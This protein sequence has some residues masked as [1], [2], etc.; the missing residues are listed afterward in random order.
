MGEIISALADLAEGPAVG[1]LM[2]WV[3]ISDTSQAATG[4][5][6]KNA[7]RYGVGAQVNAQT[8]T[9]YTYLTTDFRKLVTHTNAAAIAGTLPQAGAT[10]PAGWYMLVQNRGAGALTITPTTSTVDDAATLVLNQNEGAIVVSDGT[11]YFTFRGKTAIGAGGS[12]PADATYIVQTA[13][14]SLSA[15][16]AL[17][18]LAT[19]LL[20]S[21]TTTGVVSIATAGDIS[22][23]L[24][25][26]DAVGS[27]AYAITL[28]PAIAAYA[29]GM[30]ITFKAGT[31]NTGGATL[32]VNGLAAKAIV[33]SA[34][35]L[36]TALADNDIRAGQI[37]VVQYSSA[38]DNFQMQ[39]MLGNTAAAGSTNPTSTVIPY[40]S[41]GSFADSPLARTDAN[42]I[43]H[44]NGTS[45]TSVRYNLYGVKNGSDFE[46]FSWYYD[47]VNSKYV[48]SVNK[49]GTG[50][51]RNI[52]LEFDGTAFWR[53]HT[54]GT[55]FGLSNT[56]SV[57]AVGQGVRTKLAV[58]FGNAGSST[59]LFG[60]AGPYLNL[61]TNASERLAVH[62]FGALVG[63]AGRFGFATTALASGKT[64]DTA[65]ERGTAG[66]IDVTDGASHNPRDLKVRQHYVDQTIT[67]GG[68]TGNQTIDKASGTVN[69][70]AG[71]SAVTV[72]CNL[73]S[74][75][76]T[77]FAV[78]RTN[79]STAYVKNVVP[80]SGSFTINLGAAATAEISI[81]FFVVN[82]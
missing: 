1:D 39:S 49:G 32:A 61:A 45:S 53:F 13:H 54:G 48:L 69:I 26:V 21:T 30:V 81:G 72:T 8:G 20:K 34:G 70:A 76:S 66:R 46:R 37:V 82:K 28:S 50:T 80:G 3:D 18:A 16:Q 6:K 41:A 4:T 19:G 47:S 58:Q 64:E 67:P 35:G 38:A 52:E 42:T 65:L 14:S 56:D 51:I 15:E 36:S 59:G 11:N 12:A 74:T 57:L 23:P 29:D 33:K 31:A 68:T 43:E 5:T 9:T 22:S 40:N 78:V 79:D 63:S 60:E 77:V 27:D 17:G 71:N 73:C 55:L 2:V 10:F 44:S 24:Y 62:D 7:A 75:S 25:A